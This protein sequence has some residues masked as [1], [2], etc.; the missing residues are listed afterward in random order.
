[1]SHAINSCTKKLKTYDNKQDGLQVL[2]KICNWFN[3]NKSAIEYHDIEEIKI[4]KYDELQTAKKTVSNHLK[5]IKYSEFI[6]INTDISE[7]CVPSL[8]LGIL[9]SGH[10]FFN[11][12]T[13]QLTSKIMLINLH[14]KY[15]FTKH[16]TSN[17]EVICHF[18]IHGHS[19]YLVQLINVDKTIV[20]NRRWFYYAY[21]ITTSGSTG[22]PKVVKVLHPCILPNIT[23]L[24]KILNVTKSDKI[25]QLTSFTFDPSIVEIFLSLSCAATL[26]M[27][28]KVLKHDHKRLLEEIYHAH[29][30]VLQITPSLFFHKWSTECLKTTILGKESHLRI[31]LLGGEPFPSRKLFLK[32]SHPQNMTRLF[33]IYGKILSET[34]FE[35]RNEDNKITTDEG[36]LYIGS[37]SRVCIIGNETENDLNKPVFRNTGDVVSRDNQGRIFYKGRQNNIIKRFGNK[38]NLRELEKAAM[39]LNFVCNCAALWDT[40]KHKLYLCLSTIKNKE[41]FFILRNDAILHLRMLPAIY[42]PDKI[43][44]V[45]Y[46]KYTT[47]GKICLASLNELCRKSETENINYS[48]DNASKIFENLWNQHINCKNAG[49]LI[50]GGTSIEALQISNTAAEA[51]NVELPEMIGMLLKNATFNECTNYI[52]NILINRDCRKNDSINIGDNSTTIFSIEK[53]SL[54]QQSLSSNVLVSLNK[55]ETYWW[56]KCR[57]KVYNTHNA[58]INSQS[59]ESHLK[60]ISNIKIVAT[61]NLQ[62]CVDAS[63]TVYCTFRKELY[64]TVGS[65]SGIICTVN[66]LETHKLYEVK[67]PNR[68]EASVLVLSDFRGIVGCYDG[69]IYCIH[70]KTGEI[71]WKFQTRDMV[72]CTAITCTQESKIFVGSY[73]HHVYCLS[74]KDG[75]QIWKTKA[76]EGGICATGCLHQHSASVIFGTLD[77]SCL[78]LQQLSGQITWKRKLQDPI[79]VA[80]AVLQTGHVLFCSVSGTLHCFDIETDCQMWQYV[81]H[82]NVFSYPVIQTCKS[83]NNEYL[84]LASQNKTLYCLEM[85]CSRIEQNKPKLRYMLQLCSPVFATPWCDDKYIFLICINGAI[86]VYDISEGRL[87]VSVK[88]PKETFSSPVVHNDLAVLGC[89]DNNLYILKLS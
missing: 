48:Y 34:I 50:S 11:V 23:D 86:E 35:I 15:I 77:G 42:K 79:F 75:I 20:S 31:L 10:A 85:P 82:G 56:Y 84:I 7:Y 26:F 24:K 54:L 9:D 38:V 8:I 3:L 40:E 52:R 19:I 16:V 21:A 5:C 62:K 37:C 53:S 88:L 12:P 43:I 74:I 13:D 27:V 78:A 6:G 44:L 46:F 65:H 29:V 76:S 81:I 4:I 55:P 25:A 14:V 64:V 60:S 1:M 73:D 89:R 63:P 30:T 87:L 66:L 2:T 70:L 36:I 61:Y 18:D 58:L 59:I 49:F 17:K 80:P 28:S 41:E 83:R 32:A 22:T 33:N 39:E 72:K 57:G 51:F 47:N 68:I 67:L 45:N 71:I 69:Y